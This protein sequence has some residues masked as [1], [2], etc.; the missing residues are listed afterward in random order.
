MGIRARLLG[1]RRR[2]SAYG[3]SL[4][5]GLA[6]LSLGATCEPP[7]PGP[8]PQVR[9][10]GGPASDVCEAS[11]RNQRLLQCPGASGKSSP[12]GRTCEEVCRE[13]N[14]AFDLKPDC[15]ARATNCSEIKSC[16]DP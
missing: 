7:R 15:V 2:S 1:I 5:V 10:D 3:V 9:D 12:R 4:V 11:C 8:P 6:G 13:Q 14:A 16:F